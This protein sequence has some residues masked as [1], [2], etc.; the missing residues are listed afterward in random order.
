MKN[1]DGKGEKKSGGKGEG[2]TPATRRLKRVPR[3]GKNRIRKSGL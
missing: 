1:E 3:N 2:A